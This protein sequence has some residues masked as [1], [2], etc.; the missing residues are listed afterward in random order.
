M[1]E[2]IS[3]SGLKKEDISA[4]FNSQDKSFIQLKD[5]SIVSYKFKEKEENN[6]ANPKLSTKSISL[7]TADSTK[8]FGRM[9]S[10]TTVPKGCVIEFF[11]KVVLIQYSMMQI[12]ENQEVMKVRSFMNAYRFQDLLS[13]TKQDSITLHALD[14]LDV[15]K[16]LRT[17]YRTASSIP[18]DLLDN[19]PE[20]LNM[21]YK[22]NYDI[23]D[24]DDSDLPL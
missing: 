8:E 14:T 1:E 24:S 22:G 10:G 19:I 9:L 23:D 5:G 18:I 20:V 3:N 17:S 11:D 15:S 4:C 21:P 2:M 16:D 12:V 7:A 13:I 6:E